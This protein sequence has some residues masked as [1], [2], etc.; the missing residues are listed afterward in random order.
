MRVWYRH[1]GEPEVQAFP[2]FNYSFRPA[3]SVEEITSAIGDHHITHMVVREQITL[4][5][6]A[7]CPRITHFKISDLISPSQLPE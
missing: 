2:P 5:L 6:T 1:S 4:P 3:R 7:I